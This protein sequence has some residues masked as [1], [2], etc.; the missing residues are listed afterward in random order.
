MTISEGRVNLKH[1]I[2]TQAI[3]DLLV[4]IYFLVHSRTYASVESVVLLFWLIFTWRAISMWKE[5]LMRM[6]YSKK[7]VQC[8][9]TSINLYGCHCFDVPQLWSTRNKQNNVPIVTIG[10]LLPE[11]SLVSPVRCHSVLF[12][13]FSAAITLADTSILCTDG[14]WGSSPIPGIQPGLAVATQLL[15]IAIYTI[16]SPIYFVTCFHHPSK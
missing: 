15:Y 8:M 14:Y 10:W 12:M 11:W 3:Q 13:G 4:G 5:V 1:T 6:L 16:K 9:V 2:N 7:S